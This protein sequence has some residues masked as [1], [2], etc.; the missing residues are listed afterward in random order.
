MNNGE[1][2]GTYIPLRPWFVWLVFIGMWVTLA[3]SHRTVYL[4]ARTIDFQA[5]V[6][7]G[8]EVRTAA[9]EDG[10]GC[11]GCQ[12]IFGDCPCREAA[13]ECELSNDAEVA[14]AAFL[15]T[16]EPWWCTMVH[17]QEGP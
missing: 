2:R 4:Q 3:S 17:A 8:L 1:E 14:S 16:L 5:E 10:E 11:E 9:L 15:L 7:D 13:Y 12:V 6:L